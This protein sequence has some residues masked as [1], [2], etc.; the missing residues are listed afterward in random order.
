MTNKHPLTL[1]GDQVQAPSFDKHQALV[2]S[3]I[4]TR[5]WLMTYPEIN[6]Y[7]EYAGDQKAHQLTILL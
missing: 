6:R 7:L 1:P 4:S 3:M 2:Y 5:L